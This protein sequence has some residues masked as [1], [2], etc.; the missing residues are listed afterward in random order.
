MWV[1][2]NLLKYKVYQ[3]LKND[4]LFNNSLFLLIF[5]DPLEWHILRK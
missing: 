5:H 3:L 2:F 1:K 4:F